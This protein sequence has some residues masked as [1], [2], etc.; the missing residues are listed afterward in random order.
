M[1]R[2]GVRE[3]DKREPP[4]RMRGDAAV[5]RQRIEGGRRGADD[6]VAETGVRG[7]AAAIERGD[8]RAA[9]VDE[10]VGAELLAAR[11]VDTVEAKSALMR[12][13]ARGR[14]DADVEI[15]RATV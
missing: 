15:G 11:D 12:G 5:E 14:D 6:A 3:R 10:Q 2:G 7:G 8:Q 13:G 4:R 1:E 9:G